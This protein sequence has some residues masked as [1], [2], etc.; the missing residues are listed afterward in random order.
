MP[1]D[2]FELPVKDCKSSLITY[3][4]HEEP[5]SSLL[6]H[7]IRGRILFPAMGFIHALWSGFSFRHNIEMID[8]RIHTPL[9][10]SSM[11]DSIQLYLQKAGPNYELWDDIGKVRYA[12][13]C[14]KVSNSVPVCYPSPGAEKNKS[15]LVEGK[16]FYPSIRRLGYEYG[17]KYQFLMPY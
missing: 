8:F 4:L 10:I 16:N 14:V 17:A 5:W 15:H 7:I 2:E 11:T 6:D 9:V 3:D 13:A 12:S 1:W